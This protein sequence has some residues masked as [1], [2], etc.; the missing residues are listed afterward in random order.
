MGLTG[1][2]FVCYCIYLYFL[3]G[4]DVCSLYLVITLIF[5]GCI[6]SVLLFIYFGFDVLLIVLFIWAIVCCIYCAK[7][8]VCFAC[9]F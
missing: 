2:L 7:F 9:L 5:V 3:L 8:V 6:C 1:G 4:F